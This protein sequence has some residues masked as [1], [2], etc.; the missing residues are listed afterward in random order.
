MD[1]VL[2]AQHYDEWP[3][4]RTKVYHP[5]Y[6]STPEPRMYVAGRLL[7]TLWCTGRCSAVGGGRWRWTVPSP[8]EDERGWVLHKGI[9]RA[10]TGETIRYEPS[11]TEGGPTLLYRVTGDWIATKDPVGR[12]LP[13]DRWR[14]LIVWPD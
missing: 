3:L 14:W 1:D 11:A 8:L 9:P 13:T 2:P 7:C 6:H 5:L 12:W 10:M 4:T